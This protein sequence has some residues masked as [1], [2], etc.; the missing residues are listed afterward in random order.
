[1]FPLGNDTVLFIDISCISSFIFVLLGNHLLVS[2]WKA[3]FSEMCLC[4]LVECLR[5]TADIQRCLLVG[6]RELW[7][8]C[9]GETRVQNDTNL[10][11]IGL[12]WL[13]SV[14][15]ESD[16]AGWCVHNISPSLCQGAP[17]D[18]VSRMSSQCLHT[19]PTL[20]HELPS[21]LS[22]L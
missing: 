3:V 8:A 9:V 4:D 6:A 19:P 15:A 22:T 14:E 13:C 20:V 5:V 18:S 7:P 10:V 12:F 16:H 2:P 1:M 11:V 17:T 21:D